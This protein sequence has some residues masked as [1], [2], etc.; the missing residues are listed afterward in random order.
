MSRYVTLLVLLMLASCA[1]SNAWIGT[2]IRE[3][4]AEAEVNNQRLLGLVIGER[5]EDVLAVLGRP[6]HSEVFHVGSEIVECLFYRTM[7][8]SVQE[9]ADA[10]VQFTPVVIRD[11]RLL[12]WG[13]TAYDDI[14]EASRDAQ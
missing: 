5:K 10:A 7:G 1:G 12:G 4:R 9:P 13:Q 14:V 3:T 8:W 2:Q 11:G 6:H